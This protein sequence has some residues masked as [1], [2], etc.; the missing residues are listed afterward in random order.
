MINYLYLIIK[1]KNWNTKSN[2]AMAVSPALFPEGI[3]H[4]SRD[5]GAPR[6]VFGHLSIQDNLLFLLPSYPQELPQLILHTSP[7]LFAPHILPPCIHSSLSPFPWLSCP[8]PPPAGFHL[9]PVPTAPLF[10]PLLL[11]YL[12]SLRCYEHGLRVQREVGRRV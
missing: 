11:A 10:L 4:P 6:L 12:S 7:V 8:P 2:S 5:A 9:Y 3:Q 1:E